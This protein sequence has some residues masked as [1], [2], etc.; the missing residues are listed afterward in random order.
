MH[1]GLLVTTGRSERWATARLDTMPQPE[2]RGFS[3]P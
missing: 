3:P 1:D 2:G